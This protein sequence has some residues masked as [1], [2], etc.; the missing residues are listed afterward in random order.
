[1]DQQIRK[2]EFL[3]RS[4]MYTS[5]AGRKTY[6][7][8]PPRKN[9]NSTAG[10]LI[11]LLLLSILSLFLLKNLLYIQDLHF[12]V[13]LFFSISLVI[14]RLSLLKVILLEISKHSLSVKYTHPL[15]AAKYELTT[16]EIPLNKLESFKITQEFFVYYLEISRRS[17]RGNGVK[18][19]YFRLGVLS[20]K[21]MK[22]IRKIINT[23]DDEIIGV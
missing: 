14:W 19:F 5:E 17:E 21:Q 15:K 20:E 11:S 3:L 22:S 13:L 8:I 7:E 6:Y 1:M 9:F 18:N 10:I 16:L 12:Y 2:K 23:I 4:Y